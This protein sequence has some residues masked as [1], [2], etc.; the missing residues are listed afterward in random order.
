MTSWLVVR[1]EGSDLDPSPNFQEHRSL[2]FDSFFF[3]DWHST[4]PMLSVKFQTNLPIDD[5]ES[6]VYLSSVM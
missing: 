1:T 5:D 4:G 2:K 6:N 3:E